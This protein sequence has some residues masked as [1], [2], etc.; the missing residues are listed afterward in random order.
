VAIGKVRITTTW[1]IMAQENAALIYFAA[2]TS[3]KA[4]VFCFEYTHNGTQNIKLGWGKFS[5]YTVALDEGSV[6]FHY[7]WFK[8]SSQIL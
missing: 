8:N 6:Y 7:F 3:N 2:E 5:N 4:R 1:W